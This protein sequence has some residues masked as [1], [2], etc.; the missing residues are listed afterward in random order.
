MAAV[1]QVQFDQAGLAVRLDARHWLKCG[2]EFVDGEAR[3]SVVVTNAGWSDWSTQ[4]WPSLSMG[5]RVSRVGAGAF[6]VEMRAEVRERGEAPG[7]WAFSRICALEPL[8]EAAAAGTA[9][10]EVSGGIYFCSPTTDAEEEA[11]VT[12]HSFAI[13]RGRAFH[14]S[15]E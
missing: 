13:R 3:A 1:A 9:V 10:P 6:A 7:P 2:I 14:H 15:T 5:L 11:T 4:A 12:F 8:A